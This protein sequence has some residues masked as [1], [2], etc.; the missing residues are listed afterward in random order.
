[1]AEKKIRVKLVHSAIGRDEWQER[2]IRGLGLKKLHQVREIVDNPSTRGMVAKVPHL[3]E[4]VE[5]NI[6]VKKEP[7]K[8]PKVAKAPKAKA[9]RKRTVKSKV[10]K[11]E[12]KRT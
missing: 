4:I 2:V 1:M 9:P 8:E 12:V 11:D 10:V 7:V 3:V 6:V 5:E